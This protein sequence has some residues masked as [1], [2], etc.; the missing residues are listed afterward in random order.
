MLPFATIRTG[1]RRHV[2]A[3]YNPDTILRVRIEITVVHPQGSIE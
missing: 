3:V 2:A 1:T